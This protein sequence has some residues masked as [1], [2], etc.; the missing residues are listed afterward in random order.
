MSDA[1]SPPA[2]SRARR[3]TFSAAYAT[4]M[5]SFTST[6]TYSVL[7]CFMADPPVSVDDYVLIMRPR[8]HRG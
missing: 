1:Q 3:L 7:E 4:A 5:D 2:A 8:P 6:P